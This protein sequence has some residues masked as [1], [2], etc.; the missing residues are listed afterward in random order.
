MRFGWLMVL[1]AID[2]RDAIACGA[3]LRDDLVL[4]P[5]Y[6]DDTAPPSQPTVTWTSF[7][8]TGTDCGDFGRVTLTVSAVDDRA[9]AEKLGFR[10]EVVSSDSDVLTPSYAVL[11]LGGQIFAY[12]APTV[13]SLHAQLSVRAV[14]LNGNIGEPM[15]VDVAYE[16]P[17]PPQ[18]DEGCNAGRSPGLALALLVLARCTIRR[19]ARP[20]A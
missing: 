13:E 15:L 6:A 7:V 17:E 10:L 9:P 18:P 5:V 14:D 2:A 12:F 3:A 11:P 1:V 16:T 19:D 8:S 4:D 20:S